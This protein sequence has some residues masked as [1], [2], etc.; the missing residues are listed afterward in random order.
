MQAAL[1][2]FLRVARSGVPLPQTLGKKNSKLSI[3]MENEEYKKFSGSWVQISCNSDEIENPT[4]SYGLAPI[5]TFKKNAFVVSNEEGIILLKGTFSLNTN[6]SPKEINW[7]DT[8]GD[9][10]G[11]TFPAIYEISESSLSFCAANE[12]MCRPRAFEPKIGHTIRTFK[13]Q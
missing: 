2:G 3:E 10:A 11:K 13:R 8:Y 4:E 6:T 12:D 1:A 9:D 7:T 5:V